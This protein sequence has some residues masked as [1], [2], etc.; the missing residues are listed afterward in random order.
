[1]KK[2]M[3]I[4]GDW[5]KIYVLG[6][7]VIEREHTFAFHFFGPEGRAPG[8][9]GAPQAM[10]MWYNSGLGHLENSSTDKRE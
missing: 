1:M 5:Y 6:R 9:I 7:C 2:E 3:W 4:I 8:K 10:W